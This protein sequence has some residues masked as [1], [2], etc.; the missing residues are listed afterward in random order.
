MGG[1]VA[2]STKYSTYAVSGAYGLPILI[3]P[4]LENEIENLTKLGGE[5]DAV[6]SAVK[7]AKRANLEVWGIDKIK[8]KL[9]TYISN[10]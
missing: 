6:Q 5:Y 2:K 4:L 10:P 8:E 1:D 9:S 3:T 7:S